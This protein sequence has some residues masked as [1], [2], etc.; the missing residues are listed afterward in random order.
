MATTKCITL[1][2]DT[3][4]Q[5]LGHQ[6]AKQIEKKN[7]FQ[8]CFEN[9]SRKI[10]STIYYNFD[11]VTF[12]RGDIITVQNTLINALYIVKSGQ[13]GVYLKKASEVESMKLKAFD[14]NTRTTVRSSSLTSASNP[15]KV[16]LRS[17]GRIFSG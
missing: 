5:Y 10:L 9:I 16:L 4:R 12:N 3:F 1:D 15:Q 13:V 14:I 11:E 2:R 17:R 7:F 8:D 6:E